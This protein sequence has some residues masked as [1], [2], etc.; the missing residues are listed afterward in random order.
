MVARVKAE[1]MDSLPSELIEKL[2]FFLCYHCQHD[3]AFPTTGS[4]DA[5]MS[6][7][8]LSHL[9]RVSRR[10]YAIAQPI[11]FH[12]YTTDN[13]P[14]GHHCGNQACAGEVPGEKDMLP[15]FLRSIISRPDLASQVKTLLLVET[16][17]ISGCTPDL[18]QLLSKTTKRLGAAEH[19]PTQEYLQ[20][21]IWQ[22]FSGQPRTLMRI[23]R[24][25]IHHWLEELAVLLSPNIERLFIARD[26]FVHYEHIED[27]GASFP[28]LKTITINGVSKNQHVHEASAL[29]KAAPNL[30][31]LSS[32]R[33]SLFGGISPWAMAR[34]WNLKLQTVRRLALNDIGLEDL[35]L[36]VKCC[37]VLQQ[38]EVLVTKIHLTSGVSYWNDAKLLQAL[39]PVRHTLRKLRLSCSSI[40]TYEEDSRSNIGGI[41]W[42]FR[43][44]DQLE[45]LSLDQTAIESFS[46]TTPIEEN[47]APDRSWIKILPPSVSKVQLLQVRKGF[48]ENLRR[49]SKDVYFALPHLRVVH[50]NLAEG[51]DKRDI[52]SK[53]VDSIESAFGSAGVQVHWATT[54]V[55]EYVLKMASGISA[56][57]PE[58]LPSSE[59]M[60]PGTHGITV[61]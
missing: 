54:S 55:E 52:G 36:L 46:Q 3:G 61:Q 58:L 28:A 26:S 50:I 19:A 8:S 57:L 2:C 20:T 43:Q 31:S 27:S 47:V 13:L 30:E 17:E 14:R 12:Y 1:A 6:K 4:G 29:F 34:P 10:I 37:P 9:C 38:L 5:R 22:G 11:L 41:S 40:E 48:M 24:R 7:R 32:L 51:T 18:A 59:S 44:F 25:R 39:E 15:E 33:C 23:Q 60:I 35:E 56:G 49:L 16:D 53:I 45:E 21:K 42:S